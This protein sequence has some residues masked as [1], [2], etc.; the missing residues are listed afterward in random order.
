VGRFPPSCRQLVVG[1]GFSQPTTCAITGDH[2]GLPS[3]FSNSYTG[4]SSKGALIQGEGATSKEVQ[5]IDLS[6]PG[7]VQRFPSNPVERKARHIFFLVPRQ[8]PTEESSGVHFRTLGVCHLGRTHSGFPT[9]H[10]FRYR[11]ILLTH[12]P[13]DLRDQFETHISRFRR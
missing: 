6:H 4:S 1:S 7:R 2:T 13:V 12:F 3:F 10:Q 11:E 5:W 9:D 8:I